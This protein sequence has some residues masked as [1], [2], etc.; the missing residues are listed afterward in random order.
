M[1]TL[2]KSI[3]LGEIFLGRIWAISS[4][5]DESTSTIREIENIRIYFPLKIKIEID[6]KINSHEL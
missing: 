6:L 2:A 3:F 1:R 5:F 4:K